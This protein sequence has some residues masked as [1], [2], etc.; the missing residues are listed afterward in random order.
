MA[1]YS[2]HTIRLYTKNESHILITT[3]SIGTIK[4]LI[5][6]PHV[7]NMNNPQM[8]H[9]RRSNTNRHFAILDFTKLLFIKNIVY[10]ISASAISAIM[11]PHIPPA[12]AGSPFFSNTTNIVS[13]GLCAGK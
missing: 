12:L 11:G 4:A 6:N 5:L 10:C 7:E 2:P 8:L 3:N 1:D 13:S 9:K